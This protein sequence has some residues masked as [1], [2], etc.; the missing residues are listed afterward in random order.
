MKALY[1]D[2]GGEDREGRP[3]A[4]PGLRTGSEDTSASLTLDDD[5]QTFALRSDE[6]GGT[7]YTWLNGPNPGYGFGASPTTGLSLD[8][9]VRNIREFLAMIDPATGYIED[10]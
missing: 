8:E 1:P 9:H 2:D 7:D 6:F 4:L 10:E 5:G 3:E